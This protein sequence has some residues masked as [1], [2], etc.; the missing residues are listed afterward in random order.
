MVYVKNRH[1]SES[2][3]L[4]YDVLETEYIF[5]KTGFIVA[6]IEKAFDLVDHFFYQL[7]YKTGAFFGGAFSKVDSNSNGHVATKFFSFDRGVSQD[8]QFT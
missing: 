6:D 8:N 2:K 4:I 5:K 3:R 7:F 1:I